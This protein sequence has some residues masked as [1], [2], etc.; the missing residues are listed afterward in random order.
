MQDQDEIL[1]RV[2]RNIRNA[3]SREDLSQ[4]K[5]AHKAELDRSYVGGIERGERNPTVISLMKLARALEVSLSDLLT[6]I[7]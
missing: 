1:N 4:E 6:D 3:R 7:G 2:G 5:L